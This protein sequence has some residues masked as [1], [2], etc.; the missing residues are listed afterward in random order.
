MFP[1]LPYI[2]L[3]G[4]GWLLDFWSTRQPRPPNNFL[5]YYINQYFH[6]V[7]PLPHISICEGVAACLIYGQGGSHSLQRVFDFVISINIIIMSPPL[8]MLSCLLQV[9]HKLI[10]SLC[11]IYI[12]EYAS[13]FNVLELTFCQE[14]GSEYVIPNIIEFWTLSNKVECRFL[15]P[16]VALFTGWWTFNLHVVEMIF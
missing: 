4:C 5:L 8:I 15:L 9:Y 1:P 6:N 11:F 16:C 10:V 2:Y 7:P 3:W 12:P 13:Y 14:L